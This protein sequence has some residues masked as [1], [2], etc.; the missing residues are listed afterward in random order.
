MG[1]CKAGY[2]EILATDY[3]PKIMA[4]FEKNFPDIPT[5]VADIKNVSADDILSTTGLAPGALDLLDGSP[6]CQGF[7]IGG[8]RKLRDDKNYLFYAWANILKELQPKVFVGENVKGLVLGKMK[9]MFA[10]I[11]REL[12]S[13]GYVVKAK[14]LNSVNY[15]VP[16]KRERVIF[17]GV[18]KDLGMDP[19]FPIPTGKIVGARKLDERGKPFKGDRFKWGRFNNHI[20]NEG[21]PA[22]TVT[23]QAFF[24]WSD[25]MRELGLRSY[26]DLQTF[27]EDYIFSK[28]WRLNKTIIG[29]AVPVNMMYRIAKTIKERILIPID[30]S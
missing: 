8:R 1:Y 20:V 22:H 12:R 4:I 28:S 29:N 13:Y 11:L 16:Q 7:S 2:D 30:S 17:I 25:T 15:E 3:D 18:R 10:N 19:V 24:A 9:L 21:Y 23:T 27:P 26:A 5:L 14:V 6:P